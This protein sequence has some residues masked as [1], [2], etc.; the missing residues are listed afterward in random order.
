MSMPAGH[1]NARY[2]DLFVVTPAVGVLVMRP[3]RPLL[4]EQ[5]D[6]HCSPG[7]LRSPAQHNCH[8]VPPRSE[9]R[10]AA[11]DSDRSTAHARHLRGYTA[12]TSIITVHRSEK[13]APP[14]R[15]QAWHG[16]NTAADSAAAFAAAA[17]S[18]WPRTIL[19]Q[20]FCNGFDSASSSKPLKYRQQ[21][22]HTFAALNNSGSCSSLTSPRGA[23]GQALQPCEGLIH[24]PPRV[25]AAY[26]QRA[27]A[28]AI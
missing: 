25:A 4:L 3:S 26:P 17:S 24:R 11:G 6:H 22:R 5:R 19:G 16:I 18:G 8:A 23:H 9:V 20:R 27:R 28:C 14:L 2:V 7:R 13:H 1:H 15:C 10:R 12:N 21:P